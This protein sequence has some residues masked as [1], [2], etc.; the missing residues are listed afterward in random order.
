MTYSARLI[1]L[2]CITLILPV[3]VFA[4][5]SLQEEI[6]IGLIPEINIFKQSQR[7]DHLTEYLSKKIGIK[8]TTKVLI[9]YGNIL[10]N[11]KSQNLDGAFFGSFTGAIAHIRLNL[12]PLARPVNMDGTSTYHG[13]IIVRKDSGI[14]SVKDMKDKT[15]A[16]V[17]KATTAGYIF[18]LAYLKE[19]GIADINEFFKEYYFAGSHDHV[20]NDVLNKK[21]DIGA[22]KNT[23]YNRMLNENPRIKEEL[24]ILADSA[25]VPSNSLCLNKTIDKYIRRKLKTALLNMDRDVEGIKVL[26]KFRAINFV[27]TS[28]ADYA[29]VLDIV[30]KAGID[31]NEY[32]YMNN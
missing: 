21:A 16:F 26:E 25:Q 15:M 30:R 29:V 12:E 23:V 9:R 24:V 2:V 8:I 32:D 4:E 11:F 13:H 17:D 5:E 28:E 18:P 1:L 31:I 27:D 7:Y 20:A 3:C 6:V 14:K 22:L 10:D 19:N